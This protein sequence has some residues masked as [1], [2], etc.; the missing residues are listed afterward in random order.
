MRL[1]SIRDYRRKGNPLRHVETISPAFARCIQ[2][3][4]SWSICQFTIS[5]PLAAQ[6]LRRANID[7]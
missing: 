6:A 5:E 4:D 1:I 7:F 2:P 3:V